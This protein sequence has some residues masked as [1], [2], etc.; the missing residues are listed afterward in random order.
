MENNFH[1]AIARCKARGA[2]DVAKRIE[3]ERKIVSAL[4]RHALAEGM[5]VSVDDGG[6]ELALSKSSSYDEVFNSVGATDLDYLI[7]HRADGTKVGWFQLVYGNDGHDV[8]ADYG[9]N[10]DTDHIW[11]TVIQPL[12]NKLEG[13]AA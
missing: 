11:N 7:L 8:V 2:L 1:A 9:L 13:T 12:A 3:V 6:D 10:D 4:V 5:L